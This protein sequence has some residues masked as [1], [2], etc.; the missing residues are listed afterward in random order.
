MIGIQADKEG[1]DGGRE[2][3]AGMEWR[4]VSSLTWLTA[5]SLRKG[6]GTLSIQI[7]SS[8]L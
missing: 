2:G 6:N 5:R 4:G 1:R 3:K 7:K 8:E